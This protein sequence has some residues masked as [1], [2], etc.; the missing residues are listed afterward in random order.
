MYKLLNYLID[1]KKFIVVILGLKNDPSIKILKKFQ[2]KF[3]L[4]EKIVFFL[5]ISNNYSFIDQVYIAKNSLFYIG[6]GSGIT[7]LFYHLKKK[8]FI[9]DHTLIDYFKLPHF[10]IYRKTLFKKFILNN[11]KEQIL[12]ERNS[13]WLLKNN[14]DKFT[15]LENSYENIIEELE[16]YL[17]K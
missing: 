10:R 2:T 14:K 13:E 11:A 8:T 5:D 16:S 15:I 12:T 7:E 1:E 9:F 17:V 6:N 4:Q 3:N